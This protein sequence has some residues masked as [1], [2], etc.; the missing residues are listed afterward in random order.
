MN[1]NE[2]AFIQNGNWFE[3]AEENVFVKTMEYTFSCFPCSLHTILANMIGQPRNSEIENSWNEVMIVENGRDLNAGAPTFDF[4]ENTIRA[5]TNLLNQRNVGVKIFRPI[6][7]EPARINLTVATI[8]DLFWNHQEAGIISACENTCGHATVVMKKSDD[9]YFHYNPKPDA[10]V[11]EFVLSE[12]PGFLGKEQ[13]KG[14]VIHGIDKTNGEEWRTA[15]D[16]F[17]VLYKLGA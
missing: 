16:F 5:E 11:A 4:V 13:E 6:D 10:D 17:V 1:L 7:F 9:T 2:G 3:L 8:M 15:G 12:I 14:L